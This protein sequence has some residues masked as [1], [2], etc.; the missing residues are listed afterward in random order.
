MTAGEAGAGP[1]VMIVTPVYNGAAFLAEAIESVLAQTYSNWVHL[2]TDNGSTDDTFAIAERYAKRDH[3][4]RPFRLPHLPIVDNWNRMLGLVDD[5]AVYIKELHADDL[6]MPHCVAELV[7]LMERHPGAGMAGSYCLYDAAVS[8]VGL[9]LG[10]ELVPG[11]DM[12]RSTM[13]GEHYVFGGPSQVM[14]RHEAIRELAPD[15]YDRALRHP[16]IDLWY[17]ILG[18]RDFAFLHQ[19]LSCERTHSETQTNTFSSHYSTLALEPL[20]FLRQY[21]PRY[22]DPDAY[23]RAHRRFLNEYR[24]RLA[25]RM[26]GGAGLD[27]WR[28]HARHLA[29]YGYRLT[30][31]DLAIGTGVEL[32]LWFVDADHATTS[33]TKL[34]DKMSRRLQRRVS[35]VVTRI[36]RGLSARHRV[37]RRPF[38]QALSA[39]FGPPRR[40]VSG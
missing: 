28:Y 25:R 14:I 29:R 37:L 39:P 20:C 38:Y 27:Y 40:G 16:D 8:N 13:L 6:L 7:G 35:T 11:H 26:V 15:V 22:L 23:R 5:D 30:A 3:R 21:G 24:R 1:K 31:A 33:R 19:V 4:I 36:R 10:A 17:R 12:I 34:K 18:R 2:I 32:W 9:P